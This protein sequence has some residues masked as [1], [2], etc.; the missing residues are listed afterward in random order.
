M[1]WFWDTFILDLLAALAPEVIVEVG[2]E[3][4]RVSVPL[5]GW[6]A[7]HGAVVHV[8]EPVPLF[9]TD[10]LRRRHPGS[11]RLHRSP[12]LRVLSRL[13]APDLVL[14]DGDHN[15][16]T[17]LGEL[18]QLE[19]RALRDGR[20]PP[21]VL[22]H[23]VEW[24]YARR[25]LYYDPAAIPAS[26]RREHARRGLHPGESELRDP[27]MNAHLHNAVAEGGPANG[28]LTAV[29]DFIAESSR[30]WSMS[31]VPGLFGL[32]VLAPRQLLGRRRAV[33]ELVAGIDSPGFLR[34]QCR[35]IEA[36]RI[37]EIIRAGA[38]EAELRTLRA[39]AAR[40][41]HA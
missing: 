4:G 19:R 30:R 23:D 41:R 26:H 37:A 27:G 16:H 11:L 31:V 8:V 12:S 3:Q 14:L 28:V 25:D 32:G 5:V 40:G 7:A 29:E 35:A 13:S 1:W 39:A 34:A 38:L 9:D 20:I 33:R 10:A 21:M 24:P 6:A 2:A 36:A 15:W 22:L 18:R 17:V